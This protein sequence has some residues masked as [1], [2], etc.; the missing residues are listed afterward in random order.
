MK[1][2][3]YLFLFV[4]S[5]FLLNSCGDDMPG[6]EDLDYIGFEGESVSV[7]VN[8]NSSADVTIKV[9]TTQIQ[10]SSRTFDLVVREELTTA[11][12]GAYSIP[13]TVTVP[14]NLN[15]GEFTVTI[16]D[17]NIPSE[18][19]EAVV[20]IVAED[21]VL[22]GENLTFEIT[23]YCPLNIDD[24]IGDYLITEEGYGTYGTTITKDPDVPNRIWITNF[25]DWTNDLAY[26][27]FDPESGTVTMPS[28]PIVMGDGNTYECIG[29]GTY[30]ACA[31]TF[32]MEYSGDVAGTVHDFAPAN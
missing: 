6:T 14:A 8:K 20:A 4:A 22:T 23:K 26:Y 29:T 24:F 1:N 15:V 27:D 28:Q 25:W 2:I 3:K 31:G 18:G 9:Y 19:V 12:A 7:V 32:H 17:V 16:S 21:G 30:N 10:G 11:A 5:V 13:E